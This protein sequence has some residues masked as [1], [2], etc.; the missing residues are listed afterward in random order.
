MKYYLKDLILSRRVPILDHVGSRN[1][2]LKFWLDF[3]ALGE[4]EAPIPF[5]I[6]LLAIRAAVTFV[7]CSA[8]TQ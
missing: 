3:N 6:G 8:R 7:Q 2:I 4:K 5:H 1:E